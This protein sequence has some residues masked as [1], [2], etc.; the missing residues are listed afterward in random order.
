MGVARYSRNYTGCPAN[1]WQKTLYVFCVSVLLFAYI[2]QIEDANLANLAYQH[3]KE[4]IKASDNDLEKKVELIE[5]GNKI[6]KLE[7][8]IKDIK[9]CKKH[10]DN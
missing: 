4:S 2:I 10:Y 3:P 8:E 6:I 9:R 5:M 1:F 7:S